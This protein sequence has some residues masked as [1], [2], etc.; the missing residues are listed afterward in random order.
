MFSLWNGLLYTAGW[1]SSIWLAALGRAKLAFLGAFFPYLFQI[2]LFFYAKLPLRWVDCFLG[3]Y[4]FL[5]GFGM[6]V[7]TVN[8][9]VC[10]LLRPHIFLHF[11][12]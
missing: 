2:T 9:G 6:E 1:F 4:A 5:M 11:G 8:S 7:L 10:T 12:Y 3:F